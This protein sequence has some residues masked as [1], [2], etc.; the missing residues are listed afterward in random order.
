MPIQFT[1][2]YFKHVCLSSSGRPILNDHEH[3]IIMRNGI[4]LYQ[5]DYKL[6]N[7]QCG[8]LYLTNQRIIFVNDS[9]RDK[10]VALDLDKIDSIEV[11][12]GFLKSSPKIILKLKD[13]DENELKESQ[14]RNKFTMAWVCPICSYSNELSIN[15][16]DIENMRHSDKFLPACNTC[17]V[18][19]TYD[20]IIKYFSSN[21]DTTHSSSIDLVSFDGSQCP[22]CTFINHPFMKKCEI[23]GSQL[24]G[25]SETSSS[26]LLIQNQDKISHIKFNLLEEVSDNINLKVVK[27]S[28]RNRNQKLFFE[29]LKKAL[30]DKRRQ[31]KS[32]DTVREESPGDE[33][34]SAAASQSTFSNGI[35][36]LTTNSK[37][38]NYEDSLLLGKSVQDLDQLMSKAKDLIS[39]SKKYQNFLMKTSR[40]GQD[41]D[42]NFELLQ[43]WKS[44]VVNLNHIIDNNKIGKSINS[45]KITN[46]LNLLK[47]GKPS[48]DTISKLPTVYLEELARN[49]CDFLINDNIL[50]KKNGI[51]T[52][53]E[54]YSMYNKTRQI[55]LITPEETFDAMMKFEDLGINIKVTK[56]LLSHKEDV[57][58]SPF[59][60][61]VSKKNHS[62]SI[63]A[64]IFNY[65]TANPGISIPRLQQL[66]FNMSFIILKTILDNLVRNGELAIDTTMEGD[67]YWPN[68]LFDT[69]KSDNNHLT[70]GDTHAR[71][72]RDSLEQHQK[73]TS[74]SPAVS[75]LSNIFK[76][77]HVYSSDITSERFKELEDLSFA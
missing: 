67:T 9:H 64:K 37:Q 51:I 15:A 10:H 27:F 7:Y 17:G 39:L 31:S 72:I 28:F 71:V 21:N 76:A 41:F 58:N 69:A 29:S 56:V 8:R 45:A 42:Q 59:F 63:T 43:S 60:Y 18:K 55:N 66:H 25:S 77:S 61:I 47:S 16:S 68:E 35:H 4:G 24:I 74:D 34:S 70:M 2:P 30:E 49:I 40:H 75:D 23:C 22:N 65:I 52:F 11:Y 3:D 12:N 36:G 26:E 54:L 48:T 33:R 50:D 62:S 46:A 32:V 73:M 20:V 57:E 38:K 13:Q 14:G 19:C 5:D 1:T 6:K 44:S 53:Y